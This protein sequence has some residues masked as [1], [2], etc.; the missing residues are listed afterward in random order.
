MGRVARV[1][2]GTQLAGCLEETESG[3]RFTYEPSYEG[4]PISFRLPLQGAPFESPALFAFFDGLISE[5]WL[6]ELQS[7]QQHIDEADR[8]GLLLKNGR[9]LVGAVSV[10]P[11]ET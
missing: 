11:E 10:I 3:F 8:F 9:D 2:Y 1:L 4:A 5:G 6:L 7:R